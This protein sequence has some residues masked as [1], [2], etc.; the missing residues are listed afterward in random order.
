M[1]IGR[2]GKP[3]KAA[4][5]VA[6]GAVGGGAALAAASVPG[7]G[8]VINACYEAADGSGKPVA[9]PNVHVINTADGQ[10]CSTVNDSITYVP[11]DWNQTGPTGSAGTPGAAGATG[12]AGKTVTVVGGGTV[13][14]PNREVLTVGPA[15]AP[16]PTNGSPIGLLTFK[17]LKQGAVTGGKKTDSFEMLG[18]SFGAQTPTGSNS[19][20]ASGKRQHSPITIVKEVDS[21]SPLLLQA[22]VTN[23]ALKTVGLTFTRPLRRARRRSTSGSR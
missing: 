1:G 12:A 17:Q 5:L 15:A 14:L 7:S 13:T 18:F 2:I 4:L 3:W 23:E 16:I 11:L 19:G 6:V 20:G 21:A 22:L 8:G 9:G 10:T